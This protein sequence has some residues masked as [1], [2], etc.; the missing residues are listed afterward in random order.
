MNH[1]VASLGSSYIKIEGSSLG[2][3][4]QFTISFW[5]KKEAENSPGTVFKIGDSISFFVGNGLSISLNSDAGS[6][7]IGY[8][9][10]VKSKNQNWNH[11]VLVY[12]GNKVTYFVNGVLEDPISSREGMSRAEITGNFQ[13]GDIYL[14]ADSSGE[15]KISALMKDFKIYDKAYSIEEI[16]RNL[17]FI[18]LTLDR[19]HAISLCS[20]SSRYEGKRLIVKV[21]N[22][23]NFEQTLINKFVSRKEEKI[24]R[25]NLFF[26]RKYTLTSQIIDGA[27]V[28][29]ETRSFL[30][31]FMMAPLNL[32][33]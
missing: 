11:Y 15:N 13:M 7:N 33:Y 31:S 10:L 27:E 16:T 9:G 1:S 18:M 2:K 20:N 26:K 32:E 19:D 17:R 4:N 29:E 30:L 23:K 14:G 25:T 24:F 8:W 5:M 22:D 21:S 28:I 3:L 12:D 6:A